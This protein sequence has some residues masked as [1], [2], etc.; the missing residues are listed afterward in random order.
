MTRSIAAAVV[1][2]AMKHAISEKYPTR[3]VEYMLAWMSLAWSAR[4]LW[5]GDIMVGPTYVPLITVAP[6]Y[7]WGVFGLIFG[8][9]RIVGLIAN[10]GWKRSPLVRLVCAFIGFQFWLVLFALYSTAVFSGAPD[11]PFRTVLL[12]PMF[13]EVYSCYRCGQDHATVRAKIAAAV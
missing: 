7:V 6:E 12:V 9:A 10:G 11:F 4:V 13:F 3:S 2:A 8:A 5:P 1:L